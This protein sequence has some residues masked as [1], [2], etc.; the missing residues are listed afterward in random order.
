MGGD[1]PL[2]QHSHT[3]AGAAASYQGTVYGSHR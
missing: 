3:T 1:P 2:P